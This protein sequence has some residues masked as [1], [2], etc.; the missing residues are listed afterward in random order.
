MPP[1]KK[2]ATPLNGY[3]ITI[4]GTFPGQTQ[5]AVQN[6][7]TSLG[8]SVAKSITQDT[9]I[10]VSTDAD[11]GK[12]SKKVSEAKAMTVPIVSIDWLNDSLTNK[13]AMDTDS[14][15]LVGGTGTAT[16]PPPTNSQGKKRA[17]STSAAAASTV[18]PKAAKLDPVSSA[19]KLEPKVGEGSLAKSRDANIPVD[20]YC[21]LQ[22]TRVHVGDDG[23]IYDA[24]LNQTNASHNN[25]KFYRVQVSVSSLACPCTPH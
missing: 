13:K 23:V 14:Y 2:T 6:T 24:M 7:I 18:A 10:L 8:G 16:P 11:V 21:P 9:N 1:K 19:P 5:S 25:N 20:E 3:T 15:L 12:N 4:S 22:K 17:A